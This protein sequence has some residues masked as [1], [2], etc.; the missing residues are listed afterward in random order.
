MSSWGTCMG[1]HAIHISLAVSPAPRADCSILSTQKPQESQILTRGHLEQSRC[2]S[3]LG[4][5][6]VKGGR[7]G[8]RDREAEKVKERKLI[9]CEPVRKSDTLSLLVYESVC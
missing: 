4:G 5:P 7:V 1:S 9:F 2:Q 8:E 6:K 3:Q